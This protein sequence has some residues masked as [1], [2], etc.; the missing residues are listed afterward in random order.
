V[1]EALGEM[2]P[3]PA[4]QPDA[5]ID[6]LPMHVEEFPA[7]VG[8]T[9]A[10]GFDPWIYTSRDRDPALDRSHPDHA[11]RASEGRDPLLRASSIVG[12]DA[13]GLR[14]RGSSAFLRGRDFGGREES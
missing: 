12:S 7:M 8:F 1:R 3:D 13:T 6:V 2:P 10:T 4:L 5:W 9:G 14:R 11:L